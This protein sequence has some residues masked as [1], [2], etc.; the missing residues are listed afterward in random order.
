MAT[1][2]PYGFVEADKSHL[3]PNS[4]LHN[5]HARNAA[6]PPPHL[7]RLFTNYVKADENHEFLPEIDYHEFGRRWLALF[8]Y[9]AHPDHTQ[10]PIM[11][12]VDEVAGKPYRAVKLIKDGVQIALIPPIFDN[13]VAIMKNDERDYF[14]NLAVAQSMQQASVNRIAEASG[15]IKRNIT[16]RIHREKVL[17]DN[18]TKMNEIFRLYG[19]EREIPDWMKPYLA[20]S[21]VTQT[22]KP[23]EEPAPAKSNYGAGM[24]EED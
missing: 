10:I 9:G 16:N 11:D 3:P 17:T 15:F 22:E 23:T 6:K 24:I 21:E 5:V 13:T 7:M 2:D 20:N 14:V 1:E 4:I 18:F 12:W 8:N 19:V